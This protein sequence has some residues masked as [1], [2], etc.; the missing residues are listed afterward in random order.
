LIELLVVISIIALLISMLLPSMVGARRAGQRVACMAGLRAIA[1]GM[2]EYAAD[3][4]DWIVGSPAG[5]GAYLYGRPLAYGPAVQRYDFMGPLAHQWNMGFFE[6]SLGDVQGVKDRFNQL[7][8][9]KAF[10]CAGNTFLSESWASVKAG[11]GWMVSYNTCRY[12]LWVQASAEESG[13]PGDS[14]GLTHYSNYFQEK[15]PSG[16]RPNVQRIGVPANKVFC[17]DGSYHANPDS[18][19][20]YNLDAQAQWGGAFAGNTPYFNDSD[21]WHRSWA[22]GNN[23]IGAPGSVDARIYSYRHSTAE[24]SYGAPGNAFKG[25][26]A[27]YDGHVETQGDLQS[28]NPQQWLPRGSTLEDLTTTHNDVVRHFGLVAPV[29]IGG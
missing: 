17:G 22:P 25:N 19:P 14:T 1:Q 28:S 9:S 18:P 2:V 15:L 21:S 4:E 3:N 10:L 5:S 12:Q 13:F 27:F 11:V 16:W 26:F 23:R 29:S 6:P 20:S 7:R 24:P 8:S